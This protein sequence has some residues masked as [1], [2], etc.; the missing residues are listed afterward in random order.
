METTSSVETLSQ[1][2]I[3]GILSRNENNRKVSDQNILKY[4]RDMREQRWD[5]HMPI[6][7]DTNGNLLDGQQRLLAALKSEQEKLTT[8]VVRNAKP[9]SQLTIDC[10]KKRTFRDQLMMQGVKEAGSISTALQFMY[11]LAKQNIKASGLSN[12]ELQAAL[13]LHDGLHDSVSF[14]K[15]A[16]RPVNAWLSGLHYVGCYL[17]YEDVANAFAQAF[18]DGQMTY[19]KDAA[20]FCREFLMKDAMRDKKSDRDFRL[21]LFLRSWDYFVQKKG[22]RQLRVGSFALDGWDLVNFLPQLAKDK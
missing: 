1:E 15:D 5:V 22:M 4:S 16:F 14:C 19:E 8:V 3:R 20:V 7:I 2:D 10:G 12:V 17:G 9:S 11:Q 13:E 18:R 21:K 6:V